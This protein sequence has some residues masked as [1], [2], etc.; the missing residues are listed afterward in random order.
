MR[1]SG[2]KA[3]A[4]HFLLLLW[5]FFDSNKSLWRKKFTW[6]SFNTKRE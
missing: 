6:Q 5:L 1:K 2:K 4:E 3:K